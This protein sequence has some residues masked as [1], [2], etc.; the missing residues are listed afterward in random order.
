MAGT[1]VSSS[2]KLTS[3]LACLSPKNLL[4]PS[5]VPI[6]TG[7]FNFLAEANIPFKVSRFEMLNCPTAHFPLW[8][9]FRIL[10]FIFLFGIN[11]WQRMIL[12]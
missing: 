2:S 11:Y 1:P 8:A 4:S 3:A 7:L 6:M 9:A 12:S 5:E 10:Y